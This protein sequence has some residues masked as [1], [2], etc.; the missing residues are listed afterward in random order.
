MKS[1]PSDRSE[2]RVISFRCLISSRRHTEWVEIKAS[3]SSIDSPMLFEQKTQL[4][5]N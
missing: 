2:V 4:T 3:S 5:K 1:R